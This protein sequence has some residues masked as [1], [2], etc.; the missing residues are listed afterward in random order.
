MAQERASLL[1]AGM[2]QRDDEQS[3]RAQG[4]DAGPHGSPPV[5]D[6]AEH[7]AGDD[8]IEPSEVG[9]GNEIGLHVPDAQTQ[10]LFALD[11]VAEQSGGG[12]DADHGGPSPGEQAAQVALATTGVEDAHLVDVAQQP[13]DD[14][15]DE[16]PLG[17]PT[18]GIQRG[19]ELPV[20]RV[21]PG[22]RRLVRP[23]CVVHARTLAQAPSRGVSGAQLGQWLG[24]EHEQSDWRS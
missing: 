1:E 15:V 24:S 16:M 23:A 7:H 11:G 4:V 8:G 6:G 10:L 22:D 5:G 9:Q 19:Q 14:R 12:L 21:P 17:E 3:A 18:V 2:V 20:D 13:E